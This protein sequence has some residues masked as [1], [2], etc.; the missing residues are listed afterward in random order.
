MLRDCRLAGLGVTARAWPR[1]TFGWPAARIG[2]S[3]T[4]ASL[5]VYKA[6]EWRDAGLC[7]TGA[8]GWQSVVPS[9]AWAAADQDL[10]ETG[11]PRPGVPATPH[12]HYR[13]A[14]QRERQTPQVH[15]ERDTRAGLRPAAVRPC[16]WTCK[17]TGTSAGRCSPATGPPRIY[18][19]PPSALTTA[20]QRWSRPTNGSAGTWDSAGADIN[21]SATV[22]GQLREWQR[23]K[24]TKHTVTSDMVAHDAM[25]AQVRCLIDHIGITS[26]LSIDPAPDTYR[27]AT[28]VSL[29]TTPTRGSHTDLG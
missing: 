12:D 21:Q 11:R 24:T 7:A 1:A 10:A 23:G 3:R 28:A 27:L 5:D 29:P 4:S 25:I 22:V 18:R 15:R 9:R 17:C 6:D 13:A 14:G 2:S 8:K 26:D 20:S 19:L 16:S